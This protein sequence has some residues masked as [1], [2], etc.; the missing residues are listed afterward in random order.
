ML[1]HHV[2][3]IKNA[4][5]KGNNENIIEQTEEKQI[6]LKGTKY[7]LLFDMFKNGGYDKILPKERSNF[8]QKTVSSINNYK[9]LLNKE[10][11]IF[12]KGLMSTTMNRKIGGDF[13]SGKVGLKIFVPKG[14]K[15]V[16]VPKKF[17]NTKSGSGE[18]ELM[19]PPGTKLKVTHCYLQSDGWIWVE[20]NV[21][22]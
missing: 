18:G 11:I 22:K 5:D 13:A 16:N 19:L 7:K 17:S 8:T 15:T 14:T 10:I 12:D 21:V 2:K 20:A 9:R 4:F 6:V 3:T 1:C